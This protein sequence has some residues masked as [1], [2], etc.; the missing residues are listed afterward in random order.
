MD[1]RHESKDRNH[2]MR[3]P[4]GMLCF[5]RENWVLFGLEGVGIEFTVSGRL[6]PVV[7]FMLDNGGSGRRVS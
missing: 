2:R 1:G 7:G 3:C 5:I 4:Q 6:C